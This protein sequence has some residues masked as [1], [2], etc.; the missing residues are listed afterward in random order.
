MRSTIEQARTKMRHSLSGIFLLM[1]VPAAALLSV[2]LLA[3]APLFSS[4][5]SGSDDASW[6]AADEE[7]LFGG[8]SSGENEEPLFGGDSPGDA[9]ALFGEES[10]GSDDDLFGG[11]DDLLTEISSGESDSG[12]SGSGVSMADA[13][14]LNEQPVQIGGSFSFSISPGWGWM[15]SEE[16][17]IG[18]L[19][20]SLSTKLF[21][22]ARPDSSIRVFGKF[23]VTPE[24]G[25]SE[26]ISDGSSPFSVQELFSDFTIADSLFLRVG[27][28]KLNWGTGYFFSPAN[29]LNV[30]AIDPL[31]P[32]LE[33]IGPVSIKAN[34]PVGPAKMDNLYAYAIFPGSFIELDNLK[35]AAKYEKVIGISEIGFGGTYT[36]GEYPTLMT[37]ISTSIGDVSLF[38]EG[39]A[40]IDD[41]DSAD[42][43]GTAGGRYTWNADESDVS[44]TLAG[45]YFYNG[46]TGAEDYRHNG[47]ASLSAVLNDEISLSGTWVHSAY[48]QL[49]N[50]VPVRT[51]Q[52][53][54]IWSPADYVQINAGLVY[55]YG[56]SNTFMGT[57]LAGN[58]IG[59]MFQI[60]LGNT[61]F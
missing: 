6:A 15:F 51:V 57:E 31:N 60:S 20:S 56:S 34:L 23:D 10:S 46:N 42:F 9:D 35:Y 4:D 24:I 52:P 61:S 3:A 33:L 17:D 37:T 19:Q 2:F 48:W 40:A 5:A 27:K 30:T 13:L 18:G 38:A 44:V 22:D 53:S 8:S 16:E 1:K 39:V 54:I 45:Q 25:S 11:S 32:E 29:L 26:V 28:Q 49:G 58:T 55:F 21:F 43:S 7:A 14:L 59:A 36:Y 47:A 41:A 50:P 12:S